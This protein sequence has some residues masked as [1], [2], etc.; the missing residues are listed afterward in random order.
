MLF[1]REEKASVQNLHFKIKLTSNRIQ[2]VSEVALFIDI[3]DITGAFKHAVFLCGSRLKPKIPDGLSDLQDLPKIG[4]GRGKIF[5]LSQK[6]PYPLHRS[7]TAERRVFKNRGDLRF[8]ETFKEIPQ[9]GRIG[10]LS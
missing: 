3:K 6:H 8:S 5:A 9:N 1:A 10:V 2:K 4:S 7:K